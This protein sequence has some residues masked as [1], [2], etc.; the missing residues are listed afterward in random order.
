MTFLYQALAFIFILGAAVIIHEF[1]HFIIA[2]FFK[3]RVEVFSFGFGKRLLGFRKGDTDYRISLVPLGGYVKLG[4]DESNAPL[5]GEGATDI[6]PEEQFNLRPRYQKIAVALGG[7]VANILTA[8]AIPFLGALFIG[9]PVS[10]AP[11]VKSVYPNGAADIAGLKPG[12][13]I[14]SF[15]GAEN[16][17]WKRIEGDALL[18]PEQPLPMVV[19]R[20][21]QKVNLTIKPTKVTGNGESIGFLDF[22]PDYGNVP[23]IVEEV[24][25]S[26]P[27]AE[28]GLKPGDRLVS[29]G[30][31]PVT[32]ATQVTQYIRTHSDKPITLVYERA[33]VQ[34]EI[35]AQPRMIEG[36]MLL[37]LTP[38]ELVPKQRLGP[39]SAAG[40][41]IQFNTE[42]LRLTGKALGQVF[43]GQRNV[44]DTVSGPIG[45]ARASA[46]AA[47]RG[48]EGILLMLGFLS[49]NLGVFNLL[50]IPVLDGGAIF[51][52]LIESLLKKI[53]VAISTTIR[54]RIQY[55]GLLVLLVLMVFV[56]SN[57][58]I[59]L[60]SSWRGSKE[61]PPAVTAPA[62]Q[63]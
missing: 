61:Q 37:G 14:V 34:K 10:P 53:G 51:L 9:A 2:K 5:E 32:S 30:G 38:N 17:S 7:P 56:I 3:I 19:E 6:P 47:E 48:I 15:N 43:T 16:P 63:K 31:E 45:I 42:I 28:A 46:Q 12:D 40:Y 57:D 26:G 33:G 23:V 13:K 25:L 60:F 22:L 20:G 35:T 36:R 18:S 11:V 39:I 21:G 1:G 59:K 54:E 58:F 52:Y 41:A 29:I 24:I 62:P 55:A 27:A 4:G 50:P 8:L 49:L 44:R